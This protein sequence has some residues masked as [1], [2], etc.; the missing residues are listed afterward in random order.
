MHKTLFLRIMITMKKALTTV[1]TILVII[2]LIAT[3][4]WSGYYLFNQR[5]L[6]SEIIARQIPELAADVSQFMNQNDSLY[7]NDFSDKIKSVFNDKTDLMAITIYSYDTGIEYFYSRN[8]QV[9]VNTTGSDAVDD[10][11]PQYKGISFVHSVGSIPLQIS[12]KPG[13][14]IDCIYTV[15]PRG[16][17]FYV[18]K[19]SLI[20]VIALFFIT[21]LLI[22][23]YSLSSDKKSLQENDTWNSQNPEDSSDDSDFSESQNPFEDSPVDQDLASTDL[24]EDT[25]YGDDSS[26]GMDDSLGN[27]L[28]IGSDFSLPDEESLDMDD[29]NMEESIPD[30]PEEEDLLEMDHQETT[31]D[32]KN[33]DISD[34]LDDFSLPEEENFD[35]FGDT[36]FEENETSADFTTEDNE[37]DSQPSLYNPDS[38]LGWEHFLEERLS[39]ELER[40]ASFDQ[41]LVLVILRYSGS[42]DNQFEQF[43]SQVKEKYS[44]NDLAFEAGDNAMA[45]IDPNKDLDASIKDIQ[46]F[47]KGL[48]DSLE[49]ATI[50][51]GLS[52]RNGRLISGNRLIREASISLNKTDFE[53]PIVGFRSD[54]ERFREFLGKGN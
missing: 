24:M 34:S 8:N 49:G 37:S 11:T 54:P 35:S 21:L 33:E 27:D 20:V 25:G 4:G 15:L 31:L 3:A 22:V 1:H 18:L 50:S 39:L 9:K 51:A 42:G 13:I 38:G 52:S 36:D 30:I 2:I 41:D 32:T 6:N 26:F 47:L 10:P 43:T 45:I 40:A 17:I 28:D 14:N 16:S 12:G 53:N 48:E 7:N 5:K 19:I 23:I 46:S 44:Y 29:F